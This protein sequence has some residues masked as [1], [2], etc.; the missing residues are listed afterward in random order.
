M[1][2]V[3]FGYVGRDGCTIYRQCFLRYLYARF[4]LKRPEADWSKVVKDTEKVF[5]YLVEQGTKYGFNVDSILE[6]PDSTGDTC[7]S[8]A[9]RCSEKISK[10]IIERGIK[11]NSIRTEMMIPDFRFP[12]LSIQMMKKGINPYVISYSDNNSIDLYPSSFESEE[13]KQLLKPFPRSVHF[14]VED[15]NCTET[16]PVDCPSKFQKFYYKNGD[17][18]K[19]TIENRIG[20]GGFGSVFKGLFH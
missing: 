5:W 3:D 17:L 9:S 6:I 11:V 2:E 19:M 1:E 8:I 10:Y 15:I 7:F 13:A 14:S 4:V 20:Q 16:C 18:V 12:D